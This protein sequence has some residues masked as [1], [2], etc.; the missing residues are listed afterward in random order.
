MTEC[1]RISYPDLAFTEAGPYSL[2]GIDEDHTVPAPPETRRTWNG[3]LIPLP[4]RHRQKLGIRLSNDGVRVR[5]PCASMIEPGTR[6]DL[7]SSRWKTEGIPDGA[8]ATTL[9]RDPGL[10][11][12]DHPYLHARLFDGTPVDILR[13]GDTPPR[14]VVVA[15][16][17]N[18]L[19]VTVHYRPVI[20]C[21]LISLSFS[22][23]PSG[24][25]QGWSMELEERE[26]PIR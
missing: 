26:P 2:R 9:L 3:R 18:R 12:G 16:P 1:I 8:F 24:R 11:E 20:R 10:D 14:Q 5:L 7:V 15:R 25:E 21:V 23:T 6:V 22:G 17:G 13:N 4:R 19:P